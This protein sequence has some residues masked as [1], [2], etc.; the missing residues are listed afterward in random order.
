MANSR[1]EYFRKN[2]KVLRREQKQTVSG[3]MSACFGIASVILFAGTVINAFRA[4]GD[5]GT[6]TGTA[7]LLGLVFAA[8]A[9]AL[10]VAAFREKNIRMVLPRTG[11]ISGGILTVVFG[12]LYIYGIII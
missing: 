8:G 7:G 5:A 11:I 1:R 6:Y 12:C 9:V 2:R 10:A 4:E 3:I